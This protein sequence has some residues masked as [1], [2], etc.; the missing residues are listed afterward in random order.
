MRSLALRPGDS[1]TIPKMALSMG[2]R[3][4]VSPPLPAIHATG[5]LALT[6]AGLTPAEDTRLNWTHQTRSHGA[7]EAGRRRRTVSPAL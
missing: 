6:L 1:L 2:F 5:L 3:D 4:S 7:G